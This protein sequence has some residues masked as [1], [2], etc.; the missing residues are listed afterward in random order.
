MRNSNILIVCA[1]HFELFVSSASIGYTWTGTI[2]STQFDICTRLYGSLWVLQKHGDWINANTV[3]HCGQ[4]QPSASHPKLSAEVATKTIW[5]FRCLLSPVLLLTK[6][7]TLC[8]RGLHWDFKIPM[9][10]FN[11]ATGGSR[12]SKR[13]RRRMESTNGF[14]KKIKVDR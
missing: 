8:A 14:E 2:R 12:Q 13:R 5:I 6:I 10:G 1:F 4:W 7:P 11:F 3:N 9:G